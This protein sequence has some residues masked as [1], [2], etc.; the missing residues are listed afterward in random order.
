VAPGQEAAQGEDRSAEQ[1]HDEASFQ[2]ATERCRD[3]AGSAQ[4]DEQDGVEVAEVV[5][6][7]A[8]GGWRWHRHTFVRLDQVFAE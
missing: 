1:A 2:S 8:V 6:D 7:L 3:Q 4:G 5:K